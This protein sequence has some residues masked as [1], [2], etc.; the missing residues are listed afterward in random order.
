MARWECEEFSHFHPR[1]CGNEETPVFSCR[2]TKGGAN[3]K[4]K[5]SHLHLFNLPLLQLQRSLQLKCAECQSRCSR[6]PF[7][8]GD[9]FSS[10]LETKCH[11]GSRRRRQCSMCDVFRKR[12]TW[13]VKGMPSWVEETCQHLMVMMAG[14]LKGWQDETIEIGW[15]QCCQKL[16]FLNILW[17]FEWKKKIQYEKSRQKV[18][19]SRTNSYFLRLSANFNQISMYRKLKWHL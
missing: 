2:A 11:L 6:R 12:F 1:P 8:T 7:E 5:L 15:R 17:V 9:Q 10:G 3:I 18:L 13:K 16:F 19:S 14:L 4:H